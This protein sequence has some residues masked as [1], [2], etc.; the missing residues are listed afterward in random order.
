MTGYAPGAAAV[1]RMIAAGAEATLRALTRLERASIEGPD[2]LI[3]VGAEPLA[4]VQERSSTN[5]S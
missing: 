1:E 2:P 4:D 3:D 5:R